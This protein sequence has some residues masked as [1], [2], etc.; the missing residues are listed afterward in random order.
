MKI[1]SINHLGLV[2][3]NSSECVHFFQDILG[4]KNV[5]QDVVEEQKVSV[6][7]L[8]VDNSRLEILNPTSDESPISKYIE[9][10]GSGIH[11][12]ALEVDNLNDWL[13]Y[14][15]SKN[16]RLI[17]EFPQPGAHNTKIAFVHPHSTGG[18]LVELVEEQ[19][20]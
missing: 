20:Q 19:G 6:D 17:N 4:L 14:L 7:M 13:S 16:I 9:K 8:K 11:H 10:K 1:K 3:K 15:K 5:G 2:S 12:L 18:I